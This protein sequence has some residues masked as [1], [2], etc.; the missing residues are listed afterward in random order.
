[1]VI[2]VTTGAIFVFLRTKIV[3]TVRYACCSNMAYR[4]MNEE[5]VS[6]AKMLVVVGSCLSRRSTTWSES[7]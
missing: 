5:H 4:L 3:A 2:C 7:F 1:M 6:K